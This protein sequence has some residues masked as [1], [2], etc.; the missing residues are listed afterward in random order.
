MPVGCTSTIIYEIYKENN[1][2]IPGPIAGLMLSAILS[3]TLLLKSP[4][5]TN[6]DIEVARKLAMIANLDIEEYGMNM[7]RAG[8]SIKGMTTEEIVEQDF[9]SFKISLV[10]L[11]IYQPLK[12]EHT[13]LKWY[14]VKSKCTLLL[15]SS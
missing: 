15:Q 5:T 10:N 2:E 1:V 7:L 12:K 14:H 8:S 6:M 13:F 11:T 3:D 4:T 9:K